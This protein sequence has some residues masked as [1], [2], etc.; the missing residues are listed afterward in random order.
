MIE[1][2]EIKC[3]EHTSFVLRSV[4][5]ITF[6]CNSLTVSGKQNTWKGVKKINNKT[7]ATPLFF[8]KRCNKYYIQ[9]AQFPNRIHIQTLYHDDNRSFVNTYNKI[10]R[11]KVSETNI[12]EKTV[13]SLSCRDVA[14]RI[15]VLTGVSINYLTSGNKRCKKDNSSLFDCGS[16]NLHYKGIYGERNATVSCR[17]CIGC[18][19][20]FIDE[21]VKKIAD[22]VISPQ[23]ISNANLH[24]TED[25]IEFVKTMKSKKNKVIAT[26]LMI[27]KKINL[28]NAR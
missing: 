10:T 8:C 4:K 14:E 18:G 23:M 16:I 22:E 19:R 21:S 3:P 11:S 12:T 17:Q 7:V 20:L 28:K 9:T 15:K 6:S 25:D 13:L 27:P 2:Y 24:I 26:K 1:V 5:I